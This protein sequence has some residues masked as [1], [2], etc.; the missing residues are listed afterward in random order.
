MGLCQSDL[1]I[2]AQMSSMCPDWLA[3]FGIFAFQTKTYN[4]RSN[5]EIPENVEINIKVKATLKWSWAV[6]AQ[7]V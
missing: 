5:T 4:H 3:I 6:L 2:S 1:E 7:I